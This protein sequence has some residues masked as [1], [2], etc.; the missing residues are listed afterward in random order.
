MRLEQ[1]VGLPKQL[2]LVV[3]LYLV[4]VLVLVSISMAIWVPADEGRIVVARF[5]NA[6][7]GL[8]VL[9]VSGIYYSASKQ[10]QVEDGTIKALALSVGLAVIAQFFA[11]SL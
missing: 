8:Y 2:R 1:G 4:V 11:N 5:F 3:L 9:S 10:N 6:I 7:S